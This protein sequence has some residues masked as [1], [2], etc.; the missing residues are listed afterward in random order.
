MITLDNY[1]QQSLEILQ[2]RNKEDYETVDD[3]NKRIMETLKVKPKTD[4]KKVAE[5]RVAEPSSTTQGTYLLFSQIYFD[6]FL[7][8]F[9]EQTIRCRQSFLVCYRRLSR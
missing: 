8:S 9:Q 4:E 1:A 6:F 5:E 3:I 7:F 2:Q